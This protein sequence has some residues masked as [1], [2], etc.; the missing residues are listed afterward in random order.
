MYIPKHFQLD[1]KR[2]RQLIDSRLAGDLVTFGPNGLE[3]TFLPYSI[4]WQ[5]DQH[6]ILKTHLSRV[7]PQWRHTGEALVIINGTDFFVPVAP[8]STQSQGEPNLLK[9]PQLVP[10]WNYLAIHLHGQMS[11]HEEVD[12]IEDSLHKLVAQHQ[13]DWDMSVLDRNKLQKMMQALV[14]IEIKVDRILAKAKMSQNRSSADIQNLADKLA[15]S[16]HSL[17]TIEFLRTISFAHAKAREQAVIAAD[18][19]QTQARR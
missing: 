1:A 17:E 15:D 3:A 18:S 9:R 11:F 16:G 5:D 19:S 10:T 12:W 13:P 7:N 14:G 2:T 6:A 4:T 8:E